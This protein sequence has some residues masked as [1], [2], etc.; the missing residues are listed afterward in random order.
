M[1]PNLEEGAAFIQCRFA[2]LATISGNVLR[3]NP[4]EGFNPQVVSQPDRVDSCRY[5]G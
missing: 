3:K 5:P 4:V 1:G 2:L